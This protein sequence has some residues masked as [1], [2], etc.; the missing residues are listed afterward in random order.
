MKYEVLGVLL[1]LVA[2]RIESN[3]RLREN[4]SVPDGLQIFIAFREMEFVLLERRERARA[5][6]VRP[7]LEYFE[8][9]SRE[10]PG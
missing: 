4:V 5:F 9:C 3:P 7:A 6:A 1:D 8:Q 10:R 2:A